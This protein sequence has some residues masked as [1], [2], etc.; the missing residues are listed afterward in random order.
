[1]QIQ[2]IGFTPIKGGRHLEHA[3]VELAAAGPVG[4]RLFS[5]VDRERRRVLR[6]VETPGLLNAVASW[7]HGELSVEL[8]GRMLTAV[9]RATGEHL[10]LDYWGRA[11]EVDVVDGPWAEAYSAHL[12]REVVLTRAM[13]P[14][15]VVYGATV[16]IVTSSALRLLAGK[17]GHEVDSARFRATF[18]ID[19]EQPGVEQIGADA[20][21]E[22][23]WA[24]RELQV[25][26]ARIRVL[27]AVDRCAVID[28]DPVTGASGTR[29][30]S[31]LAGY[32]RRARSIDS[33]SVD[34]RSIDF[35][36]FAEVTVPGF[37]ER[38]DP[39]TLLN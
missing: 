20:H 34:S 13:Q 38:H 19:T 3:A 33:R 22:D 37:V 29:L 2:R 31:T 11:T 36:M 16:T 28:F 10:T 26:A 8:G 14:G 23:S 32:R 17:V 35:G 1:M 21:A 6:T 12:G 5:V 39:V 24:G 25:G 7:Q 27:E 15:A 18:V 9:P 4:D 30:L